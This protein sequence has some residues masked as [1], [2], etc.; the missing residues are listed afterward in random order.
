MRTIAV[1]DEQYA[2]LQALAELYHATPER[3]L[4]A[5]LD[6]LLAPSP[7]AGSPDIGVLPLEEYDRRWRAFMRLVGG[8]RQGKPL[9]DEEIDALI[10]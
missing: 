9:T 7:D 1:S 5:W 8:I 3:I 4:S 10:G 2:R 6:A